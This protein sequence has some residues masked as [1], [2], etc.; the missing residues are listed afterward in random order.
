MLSIRERPFYINL[1]QSFLSIHFLCYVAVEELRDLNIGIAAAKELLDP[2]IG[3]A[4]AGEL[5]DPIIGF[6][7]AEE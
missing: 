3:I 7:E 4:A 6:A 1:L 5:R 2:I